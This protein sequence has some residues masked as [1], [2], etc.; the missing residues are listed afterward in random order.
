MQWPYEP[1]HLLAMGATLRD[2]SL[3]PL[4]EDVSWAVLCVCVCVCAHVCACVCVPVPDCTVYVYGHSSP[5]AI[6]HAAPSRVQN[7]SVSRTPSN[8]TLVAF[9]LRIVSTPPTGQVVRYE[10][11]YRNLGQN[12]TNSRLQPSTFGYTVIDNVVNASSY[13]V[14]VRASVE[15]QRDP[16]MYGHS[17]WTNW[18]P[19][20]SVINPTDGESMFNGGMVVAG[21]VHE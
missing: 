5:V 10:I 14:R 7:L 16:V 20:S 9:W 17:E 12:I 1:S 6:P 11:Q 15:V 4:M 19:V 8:N 3:F 2:T 18:E 21:V 13:E